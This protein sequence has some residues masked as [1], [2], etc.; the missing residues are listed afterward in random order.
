MKKI[1]FTFLL[2]LLLLYNT[3]GDNSISNKNMSPESLLLSTDFL[4][5]A[6]TI[7]NNNKCFYP[8]PSYDIYDNVVFRKKYYPP[9]KIPIENIVT[10]KNIRHEEYK[11]FKKIFLK[12]KTENSLNIIIDKCLQIYFTENNAPDLKQIIKECKK[13]Y[14]VQNNNYIFLTFYAELLKLNGQSK[15][16]KKLYSKITKIRADK[17]ISSLQKFLQ[18]SMN[19]ENQKLRY[20][21]KNI[22][23]LVDF[24]SKNKL[25]QDE[26][27]LILRF[28]RKMKKRDK[29]WNDLFLKIK[30]KQTILPEWV[31]KIINGN[32]EI[33]RMKSAL[34]KGWRNISK[35]E[36]VY[37]KKYNQYNINAKKLFTRAWFLNPSCPEA[38]LGLL[39]TNPYFSND[40]NKFRNNLIPCFNMT[41]QAQVDFLPAYTFLMYSFRSKKWGETR[42]MKCAEA[43]LD[44]GLF[45]TSVPDMYLY[46]LITGAADFRFAWEATF[47]YERVFNKLNYYFENKFKS[48]KT[49]AEK[50]LILARA[51]QMYRLCKKYK[52][53]ITIL[54]K[55]PA[56]YDI[57]NALNDLFYQSAFAISKRNRKEIIAE[58]KAY[59]GKNG[60]FLKYADDARKK[61]L[62]LLEEKFLELALRK[63]QDNEAKSYLITRLAMTL[64]GRDVEYIKIPQN[65]VAHCAQKFK[66]DVLAFMIKHNYNFNQKMNSGRYPLGS[67]LLKKYTSLKN[68]QVLEMV[69]YLLTGGAKINSKDKYG[70][71]PLHYAASNNKS[72]EISKILIANDAN[73]N[74]VNF[75]TSTPLILACKKNNVKIAKYLASLKNININYTKKNG[76]TA[77]TYAILKSKSELVRTLLKYGAKTDVK[78]KHG[79]SSLGIAIYYNKHENAQVLINAGVDLNNG[80]DGTTTLIIA[81]AKNRIKCV[82]SLL[83]AGAD[84]Y[85]KDKYGKD[86]FS[87]I[88][89]KQKEINKLLNNHLKLRQKQ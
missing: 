88:K 79:W 18:T 6:T 80:A 15:D 59:T 14:S 87:Y 7:K 41:V 85:L 71:S 40:P 28:V 46:G 82:Q 66:F 67:F 50:N 76:Y 2:L 19:G 89:P 58:L 9:I 69:N 37:W 11:F 33:S 52:K 56:E 51:L 10:E 32:Y 75:N 74:A 62:G 5:K 35:M 3:L 86:A 77:L 63:E 57:A 78:L 13:A 4:N 48:A 68:N 73:I 81:T 70:N 20:L 29:I 36:R 44:S 43:A 55:L 8:Q 25:Q 1:F 31:Y 38:A 12:N 54:E 84:P 34:N 64:S 72:L 30:N 16:A 83:K 47:Q 45:T 27:N 65:L 22:D 23:Y 53:V 24:L 61:G 21:K 26:Y 60:K 17:N 49:I 39:R 42:I